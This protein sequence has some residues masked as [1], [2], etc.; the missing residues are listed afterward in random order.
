MI[1]K[2]GIFLRL[3]IIYFKYRIEKNRIEYF[4]VNKV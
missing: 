3:S 2:L 4:L 1:N